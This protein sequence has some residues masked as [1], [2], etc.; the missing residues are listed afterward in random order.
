LTTRAQE[1]T[2]HYQQPFPGTSGDE[3]AAGGEW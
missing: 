1:K 2:R 3:F